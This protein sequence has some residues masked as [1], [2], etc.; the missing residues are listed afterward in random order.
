MARRKKGGT[1]NPNTRRKGSVGEVDKKDSL[2]NGKKRVV[3]AMGG[4]RRGVRLGAK[5]RREE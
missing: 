3:A 1:E 5:I 4:R 2:A